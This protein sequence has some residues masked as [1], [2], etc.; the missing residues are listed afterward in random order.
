MKRG[1]TDQTL[2]KALQSSLVKSSWV[3][4]CLRVA[5]QAGSCM[6]HGPAA[7]YTSVPQLRSPAKRPARP[8]APANSAPAGPVLR[9]LPEDA[10]TSFAQ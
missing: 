8:A 7:L 2:V 6:S 5:R 1:I 3:L 9:W 10:Y 4:A